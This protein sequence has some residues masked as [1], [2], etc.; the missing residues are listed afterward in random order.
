[1]LIQKLYSYKRCLQ[2]GYS[3]A[4]SEARIYT[5]SMKELPQAIVNEYKKA[6]ALDMIK[7]KNVLNQ[8]DLTKGN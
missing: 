1:M 5:D 8:L 3:R 6:A 2:C 4:Q 7:N